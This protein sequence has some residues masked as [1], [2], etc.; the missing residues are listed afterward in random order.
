MA[1]QLD[2]ATE[3][4]IR[5][6]AGDGRLLIDSFRRGPPAYLLRDPRQEPWRRHIARFMDRAIDFVA[7]ADAPEPFI[8][9]SVDMLSAWPEALTAQRRH[10]TAS[11]LRRAPDRTFMV[12]AA[13]PVL[14]PARGIVMTTANA[15]DITRIV[16]AERTRLGVVLA[17]VVLTSVLLSLFLA[18]T[19]VRP[20]RRLAIAAHRVRLGRAREVSVPFSQHRR[21]EIGTLARALADMS[22]ALHQRI[23]ATEAFAADVTHELKNPLA[24]LRSAID[25]LDRVDDPELRAQLQAVVRDDVRR[26]DRLITDISEASRVD[27]ELARARFETIDLGRMIEGLVASREARGINGD[28]RVAYARPNPGTAVVLG[29]GARLT[30]TVENLLDNAISFSPPSGLVTIAA[31]R[32]GDEAVVTVDDEGPGVSPEVR[33][34]IFRR[35]TS[36]RPEGE[37]FGRHSGLGL[38]IAKATVE[39]HNGTIVVQDREGAHS[40]ARFVIRLPISDEL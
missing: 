2:D 12:S 9:P 17:I 6:Y 27:A 35:F 36:I 34:A 22:Q 8:E 19:I 32:D 38:A 30:R 11:M 28:V 10:D 29:D 14:T 7:D 21:D 4:R 16:R 20:L 40:G 5:L 37:A 15:R 3:Q 1:D 25:S 33:E 13:A 24:S 23:D 39:G 26:L 18:R 31:T